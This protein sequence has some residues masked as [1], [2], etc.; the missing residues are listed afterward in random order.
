MNRQDAKN[1]KLIFQVLEKF[2]ANISK[3]WKRFSFLGGLGDLA[4]KE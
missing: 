1:A 4:V 3:V 2:M